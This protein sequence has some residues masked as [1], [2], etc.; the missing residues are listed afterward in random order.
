MKIKISYIAEQEKE[1]AEAV[2]KLRQ[3]FPNARVKQSEA[4]QPYKLY[5]LTI[6]LE[7]EQHKSSTKV[8][9]KIQ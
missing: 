2:T 4:K 3:L 8:A 9:Q 6:K 5:Y 7:Q 1:A